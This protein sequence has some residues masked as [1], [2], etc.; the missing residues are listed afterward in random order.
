MELIQR[1]DATH[2][3]ERPRFQRRVGFAHAHKITPHMGPAERQAK[4]A[5][6][7][8]LHRFV[9]AVPIDHQHSGS[10]V[11]EVPLGN[12]VAATRIEHVDH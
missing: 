4:M 10:I 7:D 9:S 2:P 12:G 11:R 3:L 1:T 6:L 8:L 5:F